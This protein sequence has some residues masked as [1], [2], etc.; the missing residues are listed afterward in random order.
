MLL[1]VFRFCN[2]L[3]ISDRLVDCYNQDERSLNEDK[4]T[5]PVSKTIHNLTEE[6]RDV[7][8]Q[9]H[10]KMANENLSLRKRLNVLEQQMQ[11]LETHCTKLSTA[12]S[13]V[14]LVNKSFSVAVS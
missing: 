7:V 11:D 8:E 13:E 2:Q 6:I 3:Y 12:Q 1:Y 14:H 4:A 10:H 5:F 9:A